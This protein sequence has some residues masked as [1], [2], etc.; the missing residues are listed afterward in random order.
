MVEPVY[1]MLWNCGYC[2][3]QKLLG[4][5]HRHCPNCGAKQDPNARYFPAEHEKVAVH[6]HQYV[7]ADLVCRYCQAACSRR[8]HNCGQCGAPLAEGVAVQQLADPVEQ[9]FA[10]KPPSTPPKR[11]AWKIL[12]PIVVLTVVAAVVLLLV[13]KREERFVVATHTW[14]RTVN[15]ERFGPQRQ[16][17]WCEQL[18]AGASDISRHR[19]RRGSKQV[20]DGEDCRTRK[21]DRGDGT[22]VETQECSP[23]YRDE[24]VYG[25]KCD[26]VVVRWSTLRQETVEGKASAVQPRWPSVALTR[27]GCTSVGCE[28]EGARDETYTVVFRDA[29]GAQYRCDFDQP[30]WSSFNDGQTYSGK[31]RALVG[32]LDCKSLSPLR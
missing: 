32:S 25:D 20:P 2:G 22:F 26:Y 12:V 31:L 14:K 16:S 11:A 18:P 24:P 19:E 7:G 17:A 8:A 30:A 15:V 3:T 21:K 23:K 29:K 28:R 1:E 5:T 4:L 10:A 9:T 27:A 13:W 6:S